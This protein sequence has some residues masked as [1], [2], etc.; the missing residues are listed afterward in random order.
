MKSGPSDGPRAAGVALCDFSSLP[1]RPAISSRRRGCSAARCRLDDVRR[2]IQACLSREMV[3]AFQLARP[4]GKVDSYR[5]FR[6]SE[7]YQ[8]SHRPFH[9]AVV[10]QVVQRRRLGNLLAVLDDASH[11]ESQRFL[12]HLTCLFQGLPRRHTAGEVREA[13]AEVRVCVLVK[14]SYVSYVVQDSPIS[15]PSI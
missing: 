5:S 7:R 11:V 13:D 2:T 12:C 6:G 10:C 9:Y 3:D 14:I 8:H 1:R 15:D 4:G